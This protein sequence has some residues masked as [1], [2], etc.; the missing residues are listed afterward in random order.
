MELVGINW[1]YLFIQF[2]VF[3]GLV[4]AIRAFI[5]WKRKGD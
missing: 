2:G 5:R 1:G 4:L 3:V